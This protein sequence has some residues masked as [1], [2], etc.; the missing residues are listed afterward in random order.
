[1]KRIAVLTGG[2]DAP[3]MN[4]AVRSVVRTGIYMGLEVMGIEKAYLGMMEDLIIPLSLKDVGGIMQ[5]GGTM[6]QTTRCEEFITD[7]GQEQAVQNLKK[8]GIEGLV[9]IG[10]DGSLTG[11]RD[12]HNRG[13][14][15]IGIPGTIDN[16]LWGTDM[17]IGVDTALNTIIYCVDNIKDT[18]SSHER[19]FIIEVMGRKSGYLALMAAI[20]TG[21]EEVYIP[22]KEMD[23]QATANKIQEGHKRGK[24]HGIIILAEGAGNA[25]TIGRQLKNILGY[26]V[27][28]S[29]LGHIQRGG[30]P[31]AFDRQLGS[32]MGAEAVK[33]L[34][35]GKSGFMVALSG[36]HYSLVPLEEAISKKKTI[37]QKQYE[38]AQVLSL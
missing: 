14:K 6:L 8:H 16:D 23:I 21:A 17:C 28:I 26:E 3:G 29:I 38:M 5:K 9:V 7:E 24:T 4:A 37:N 33:A 22:E 32:M 1:M 18:A 36:A 10:G 12:L 25:Y 30:T 31:S 27:R 2:G 35:D 34:M 19:A 15:V 11:A 20:A 13:I